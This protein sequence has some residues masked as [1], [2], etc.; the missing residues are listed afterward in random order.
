MVIEWCVGAMAMAHTAIQIR[1]TDNLQLHG[2]APT[3]PVLV[4]VATC[5]RQS[6]SYGWTEQF[7]PSVAI[8]QTSQHVDSSTYFISDSSR[9]HQLDCRQHEVIMLTMSE[10]L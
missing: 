6:I 2:R 4:A 3:Q 8:H 7:T 1:T 9:S 10:A 5:M